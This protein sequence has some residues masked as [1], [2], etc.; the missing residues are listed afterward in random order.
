MEL[1]E[2][3]RSTAFAVV[4]ALTLAATGTP[5]LA[6]SN[7]ELVADAHASANTSLFGVRQDQDVLTN[8][9][10]AVLSSSAHEAGGGAYANGRATASFGA[11]HAYADALFDPALGQSQA[12]A[13]ATF[14]DH[15]D[16]AT[17]QGGVTYNLA[18]NITGSSSAQPQFGPGPSVLVT[19]RLDDD[20]ALDTIIL[21]SWFLPKNP[22]VVVP[23]SVPAGHFT[24]FYLDLSVFAYDGVQSVPGVVFADYSDTVIATIAPAA[25][26][27]PDIVSLTGHNYAPPAA[28][29]P[30][31]WA[32]MILGLGAVGAVSRRM[33]VTPA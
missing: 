8:N 24:R 30:A 13:E 31:S 26:G 29:E 1:L 6:I 2:I 18:L 28:P 27:R 21:G 11:L 17:F 5:A 20:T 15:F 3:M 10:L 22:N 32:L 14:I 19:W 12:T 16:G 9:P 7:G 33:P 23:F 4:S 25:G